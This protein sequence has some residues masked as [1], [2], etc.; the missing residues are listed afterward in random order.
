MYLKEYLNQYM[1]KDIKLFV[2]MDGVRGDSEPQELSISGDE[3]KV[4]PSEVLKYPLCPTIELLI[5]KGKLL[6][7]QESVFDTKL[8]IQ[9]ATSGEIIWLNSFKSKE[10]GGNE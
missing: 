8:F 10:E 5:P 9:I 3:L 4:L 6:I 2:D 1:G 7:P